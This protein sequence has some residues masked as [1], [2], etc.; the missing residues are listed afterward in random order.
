VQDARQDPQERAGPRTALGLVM[1]TFPQGHADFAALPR[2]AQRAEAEG[3]GALWACDHVFWHGPVLECFTALSVAAAVTA[4]TTIGAAIVQLPLRQS[5]IVAKTAASIQ[6]VAGGRLVLGIGVGMHEAEFE[7]VGAPFAG[8]GARCDRAIGELRSLWAGAEARRGYRQDPCPPAI[9][10][11][12][13]GA[14]PAARRRAARLADGWIPIFRSPEALRADFAALDAELARAGRAP[15]A[16]TRS[17]LVF[18]A[19]HADGRRARERGLAW[20]ASLYRL[21]PQK[22]ERHLLAGE[23]AEVADRLAAYH[24]AGVDHFVC[25][26]ADDEPLSHFASIATASRRSGLR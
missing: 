16:V 25:F 6:S 12:I 1:P 23:P 14:S 17:L 10:I 3:V 13:G 7:L 15:S 9:P 19:A 2:W 4:H 18:V 26:V 22:V 21:P 20:L 24:D 8:R 5:A 11:W